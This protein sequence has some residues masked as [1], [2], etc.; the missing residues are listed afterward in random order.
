[1]K[2]LKTFENFE[3]YP[4]FNEIK[5]VKSYNGG[6]NYKDIKVGDYVI[7]EDLAYYLSTGGNSEISNFINCNIGKVVEIDNSWCVVKYDNVPD[8]LRD[9]FD[10]YFRDESAE[11][12]I[13]YHE[14][15]YCSSNKKSLEEILVMLSD[16]E[17]Y[18]L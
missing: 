7:C 5:D 18:N 10:T 15:R 14:I 11:K 3:V 1:M 8:D 16:I 2:N 17:K 6:C 13:Y 4:N 12:T 9:E